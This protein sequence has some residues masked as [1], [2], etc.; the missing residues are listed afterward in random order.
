MNL[1]QEYKRPASVA[2]AIQFLT[3]APGSALPIAG[4]N[5]DFLAWIKAATSKP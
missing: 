5:P 1:W 2:E 3:S 4:G